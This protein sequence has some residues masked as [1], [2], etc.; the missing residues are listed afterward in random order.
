[1]IELTVVTIMLYALFQKQYGNPHTILSSYR[2]EIKL[3]E[4]LNPGDAAAFRKFSDQ[5][6]DNESW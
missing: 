1:M 6:S 4:P 5:M 2:K 3:M